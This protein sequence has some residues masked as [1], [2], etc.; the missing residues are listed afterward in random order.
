MTNMNSVQLKIK[1]IL[2]FTLIAMVTDLPYQSGIHLRYTFD[3]TATR[4]VADTYHPK[5]P[6]CHTGTQFSLKQISY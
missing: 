2:I 4:Y 5:E 1:P 3:N 6:P